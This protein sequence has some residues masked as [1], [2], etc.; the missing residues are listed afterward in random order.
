MAILLLVSHTV[1]I[2][3]RGYVI[4]TWVKYIIY[5]TRTINL[6]FPAEYINVDGRSVGWGDALGMSK[7]YLYYVGPVLLVSIAFCAYLVIKKKEYRTLIK[8]RIAKDPGMQTIALIGTIYF[9]TSEI[10]PRFGGLALLPERLWTIGSIFLSV[11]SLSLVAYYQKKYRVLVASSIVV[12]VTVSLGASLYINN[13]KKYVVPDYQIRSNAW[14]K[15]NLPSDRIMLAGHYDTI[16]RVHTG[17]PTI[18]IDDNLYCDTA[19]QDPKIF[20]QLIPTEAQNV[21]IYYAKDHEKNPYLHRPYIQKT[22]TCPKPSFINYPEH[23]MQ[24]YN[25]HNN[26][27]I[28]KI[29]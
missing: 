9:A 3:S 11:L 18:L 5:N 12:L 13:L 2:K 19:V 17:T 26:V 15:K 23:Y 8:S 6:R 10:L 28:W 27:I 21:Y 29:Q 1:F 24:I 4:W 22:A 7:Y 16:L 20:S 14:I 25:D